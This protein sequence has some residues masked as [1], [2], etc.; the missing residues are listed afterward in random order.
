MLKLKNISFEYPEGT[1]LFGDFNL[2][3]KEGEHIAVTGYSGSGKSSL[4]ALIYGLLD[5]NKGNIKWKNDAILGPSHQLVPGKDYMKLV[6]QESNLMPYTS[7]AENVNKHLSRMYPEKNK[8]IVE[9]LL[10]LLELIPL[11]NNLVKT[12]SGGEKQRV[13][14]AQALAK[15][16]EI[17]L[18]DEPF[19]HLD[20]FRKR[21]LRRKLFHYLK[22]EGITCL[23]ATHNQEEILSFS[24]KV[25][26]LK[27]GE[28]VDF[29]SAEKIIDSPKNI[30]TASIFGD[31]SIL[32]AMQIN[33]KSQNKY[34]FYPDEIFIA[35]HK[36]PLSASVKQVYYKGSHYLIELVSGK[37]TILINNKTP[38]EKHCEFYLEVD[39]EK[40]YSDRIISDD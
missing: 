37:Q 13:A 28:K 33:I 30:Y 40:D 6:T 14:L 32:S 27:D 24:E 3:V 15:K 36:T 34:V 35:E 18:L 25:L 2:E 19:S 39:S 29:R 38:L 23:Y 31:Y 1:T 20:Q 16:P 10:D 5:L 11:K 9:E 21:Q 17:L 22:K 4:L 26:I 12:L 8:K 7:A